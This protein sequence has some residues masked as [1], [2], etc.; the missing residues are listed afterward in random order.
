MKRIL[1]I[2]LLALAACTQPAAEHGAEH[3]DYKIMRVHA[4][5]DELSLHDYTVKFNRP[6]I[7]AG[8]EAVLEFS[9]MLGE[10]PL[11]LQINHGAL[12]HVIVV[13]KDLEKFYHL[14]PDEHTPGTMG[15][16]HTFEEPGEYR[17]WIEFVNNDLEHIIDYNILVE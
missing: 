12:M 1:A 2:I 3:T 7:K 9:L 4:D 14:H 6:T 5:K 11:P 10:E 8:E 17:I 13:S 15:V 16:E